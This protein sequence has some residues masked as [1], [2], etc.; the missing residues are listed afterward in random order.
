MQGE[1]LKILVLN[2]MHAIVTMGQQQAQSAAHGK[3]L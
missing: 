3:V 1:G 2:L